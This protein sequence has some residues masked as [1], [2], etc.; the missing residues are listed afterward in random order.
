MDGPTNP[1]TP[2]G[3]MLTRE[4]VLALLLLGATAI[5]FF[6]CYQIAEPF[7][8]ALGWALALAVIATPLHRWIRD[9]VEQPELAAGIAVVIVAVLVVGPAVYLSQQ[10][11][12]EANRFLDTLRDDTLNDTWDSLIASSPRLAPALRWIDDVVDF[13]EEMPRLAAAI[14][15]RV[16]SIAIGAVWAAFQFLV[17]LFVFFYSLRDRQ[18]ILA[19]LRS[20]LPLSHAEFEEVAAWVS[21]TIYATV[22]GAVVVAIV[23]GTLAGVMFWILGI[24]GALFWGVIMA[25]LALIPYLGTFVIWGPVAAYLAFSGETT[26]ALILAA[27]GLTAVGLID[28]LL[29]PLLVGRR[30]RLHPL[31]VFFAVIGGVGFFGAAGLVLG[32]VVLAVTVAIIDIWR[33]RFSGGRPAEVPVG[34][35]ASPLPRPAIGRLS[36]IHE[37]G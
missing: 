7:I 19:G 23:Q 37:K 11:A 35:E 33:R 3:A 25:L 4:R 32:P 15:P 14:T 12:A 5:A 8:P 10:L 20:L 2:N 21:D 24:P 27:W 16:Q 17:M 30:I 28:N 1:A 18:T 26:K 36:R 6:L 13:N 9:R 29:Y 22:Y 34:A 31:P